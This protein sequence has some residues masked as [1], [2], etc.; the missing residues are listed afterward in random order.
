M[1]SVIF[2]RNSGT[3]IYMP[4]QTP[5]TNFVQWF[6]Q[7]SI[8]TPYGFNLYIYVCVSAALMGKWMLHEV[9]TY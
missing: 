9:F 7:C 1:L 3:A 2:L 5:V 6:I 8:M 4:K